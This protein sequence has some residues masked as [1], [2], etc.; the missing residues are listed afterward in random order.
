MFANAG[1][2]LVITVVVQFIAMFL[3]HLFLYENQI[4]PNLVARANH[5]RDQWERASDDFRAK[6]GDAAQGLAAAH[7]G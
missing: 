2:F 5:L 7:R 1:R 3:R 6:G 4:D